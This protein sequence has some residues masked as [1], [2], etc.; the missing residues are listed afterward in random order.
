MQ[1]FKLGAPSM[2]DIQI[3]KKYFR[4]IIITEYIRKKQVRKYNKT[5]NKLNHRTVSSNC[6]KYYIVYVIL[7]DLFV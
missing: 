7:V 1:S 5:S 4:K 3:F 2:I 6:F